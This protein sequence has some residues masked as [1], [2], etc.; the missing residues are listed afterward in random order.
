LNVAGQPGDTTLEEVDAI[1]AA[2][3]VVGRYVPGEIFDAGVLHAINWAVI[4]TFIFTL[5]AQIPDG[6]KFF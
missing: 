1:L 6:L 2:P 4:E 3:K 5:L